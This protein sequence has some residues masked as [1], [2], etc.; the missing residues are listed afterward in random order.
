MNC[1]KCKTPISEKDLICP[2]C[3]RVIRIQCHTCDNITK[4]TICEKCGTVLVNKCYKCG[5]LNSTTLENCPKCGLNINASI[6]LRE[7]VIEE[8]AVL[9]IEVTNFEDIKTAF[10][11]D[12]ITEQ[13]KYNLYSVIKKT[14]SQKK[15]RVQFIDDTYI[16]RFC[17]D[18]SF[19]ESCKSAIDFSIY[20]A[21]TVSEI[22]KK[23]FEAKGVELKVQMA[24]QKR[25]VY[26]KPSEYKS[27]LN[28]NVVYSSS[29]KGHL[30][31]NTEVVVDSYIYQQTKLQ[32]PFQS[33]SAVFVKNQM[34]MFF[35]LVLH[36]IIQP[37]EE[38]EKTIEVNQV[39]LPKNIDF[40]PE[41]EV[42]DEQLINFDSLNC[43]FLRAKQENIA[44]EL[45]KIAAK[46]MLNPIISVRS[47][48]RLGKLALCDNDKLKEVFSDYNLIR[49]SCSKNN[50][51]SAYGLMKEML[52]AY[53][54]IDELS[55]LLNN[56]LLDAVSSD[57]HLLELFRMEIKE[58]VHPEDLRYSYYEAFTN[59]IASIPYKT[60]FVIEDFENTDE[61]SLEIIKYLCENKKLGNVGFLISCDI[62]YSL[63]RKIYK[64]MTAPNYYDIEL[65]PSSNKRIVA[66]KLQVLKHIQDSFFVEKALENTKGSFFY[67]DTALKYLVDDE[68]L[69]ISEGKYEIAKDRMIV[70]PKDLNELI[71]KR[72]HHLQVK[73]NA[74]E[75][76]ASLLLLGEKNEFSNIHK[77][78]FKEDIKL[79]KYL[80]K[81]EFIKVVD[82]KEII[83]KDFN[84]YSKNFLEICPQEKLIEIS[85]NILE[86][87][88][89][90]EQIPNCNK[91]RLLEFAKLKKEAFAQWHALA[92]ISSQS[93]DFCAYLNC[94][95][96]FLSLVDNVIDAETDKT[97]EQVKMDVYSELASM[98]YKYYPDK[99]R[100]FLE[101]LL[102]NLEAQNDDQR[103]KEVANKLVQSCLMS[104]NYN[105]ALEYIGKIISRTPRSSF[106]PA[107][108]NFNLNY[109]LVNLVTLEIYFNLGRLNE[110]IELGDELF[111]YI[112][113]ATITDNVLPEGFSKKQF[114]EAL[115]D[116][117]FFV[118]ISRIILLKPDRVDVLIDFEDRTK[119]RFTFFKLLYLLNEFLEGKNIVE[120]M[121][122]IANSGLK[123]KYSQILFPLIQGLIAANY[124]DWNNLGNYTYNAKL[125]AAILNQHQ[126]EYFADLM[127]GFAYQNL[128]NT[129]KAKQIYYNIL[130]IAEEK[131]I[132]NI[133][134]LS[135]I[136]IAKA[137]FQDG[138]IDMSVGII[139]NSILHLEKDS[140]ASEFFVILFKALSAEIM[141]Y[142]KSN[143]E[144]AMFCAEQS[145]ET[146]LKDKLN[147]YLP[148]FAN[149]LLFIYNT[150]A[151]GNKSPQVIQVIKQ[152]TNYI[153]Q[154]MNTRVR[155][156]K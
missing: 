125:V 33:L 58:Q 88:Y 130:D 61:G 60:I 128:G 115:C 94:T 31:N 92:M 105:N 9:T 54:G 2:K 59:F 53:R 67:F 65:K 37:E 140:D 32:Y 1:P 107:D 146:S 144:K 68:I 134:Y 74:Y 3:K 8:F 116:A 104:G 122:Q 63:H 111:K 52:L 27:G 26:S 11:S 121:N 55:M 48:E 23:L 21:Q 13:F 99:I 131:G 40:E 117:M 28:I 147:I 25:D 56:D 82:D 47:E 14:A 110:C 143:I 78:G 132:K 124:Q 66:E 97:V 87:I 100:S 22:N 103:I 98:M 24:V 139:N 155:P 6:G 148:Q 62:K 113:L 145:F 29:G 153:K 96:K 112:D 138:N 15:L 101:T 77:L 150:I 71:Q 151:A 91:A 39:K 57:V 118:C 152:K 12:K 149:M 83:I 156:K 142:T 75:F 109:F 127:I 95:N 18:F 5:K 10:K 36:K 64:L 42:D 41:E 135:W 43:T 93:G 70:I 76:Y 30:Y 106:N 129:K 34:V 136:L 120:P 44:T 16:I 50:K 85:K 38:T 72:I 45:E 79:V 133:I 123:D 49:F 20:V 81:K 19:E 46:N 108:E 86:S 51:Y 90:D 137:E 73:P 141:I 89:L 119:T 80:E 17:K 69:K 84:I 154:V 102:T 35:E 126:L 4:N 114:E 7:S